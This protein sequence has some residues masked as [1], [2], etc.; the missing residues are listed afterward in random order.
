MK[1]LQDIGG[2]S[3]NN[4]GNSLGAVAGLFFLFGLLGGAY[5]VVIALANPLQ[6]SDLEVLAGGFILAL[7][8]F[9]LVYFIRPQN[10]ETE[11][12]HSQ[13]PLSPLEMDEG[14][15][16]TPEVIAAD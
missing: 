7:S 8:S 15:E 4:A 9:L 11:I 5:L 2:Q 3:R 14:F 12:L 16:Q 13:K 10:K 6:G 1:G